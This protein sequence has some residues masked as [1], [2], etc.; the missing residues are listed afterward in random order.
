MLFNEKV[1]YC[2]GKPY[3]LFFYFWV[4]TLSTLSSFVYVQLWVTFYQ[5]WITGNCLIYEIKK[6][7]YSEVRQISWNGTILL[8]YSELSQISSFFPVYL[9]C[10]FIDYNFL[11]GISDSSRP[12]LV[13][14][15]TNV[16]TRFNFYSAN[17][18]YSLD[19]I[20]S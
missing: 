14:Y 19:W 9:C 10:W 7:F 13:A 17:S 2:W 4:A 8:I 11:N 16:K 6:G 1:L 5:Q 3:K 12:F 18:S 20:G 15:Y